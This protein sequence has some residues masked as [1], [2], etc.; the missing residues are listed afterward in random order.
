MIYTMN[1]WEIELTQQ[2]MKSLIKKI[3]IRFSLVPIVIGFLI[4]LP[5]GTFNYWQV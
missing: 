3:I 4:L 1:D 5:A 2:E